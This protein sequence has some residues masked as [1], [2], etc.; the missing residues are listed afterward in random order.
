MNIYRQ[1]LRSLRASAMIWSISL[2]ALT[3]MFFTIFT[4]FAKD[5]EVAMSVLSN[6]PQPVLDA[7]DI[8]LDS[9]FSVY[10]FFAYLLNFVMLA[11]A[12]QAM[13]LGVGVLARDEI[14]KTTDFLLSKPVSRAEVISS[15]LL[16]AFTIICVTNLVFIGSALASAMLVVSDDFSLQTFLLVSSSLIIVQMVFLAIGLVTSQMVRRIKSI[17]GLSLPIVFSF[18]VIGMLGAV[19]GNET[20]RYI[21]P[22]KYFDFSHIITTN[23]YELPYLLVGLGIIVAA[24]PLSYRLYINRDIRTPA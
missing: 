22:F 1:E 9:F 5:T 20:S 18:F 19:I 2:G 14:T 23:S 8:N 11:G 17:I 7:L 10:G 16:A 4:S 13:S 24:T 12:I 6:L 21:S 3:A 15:K